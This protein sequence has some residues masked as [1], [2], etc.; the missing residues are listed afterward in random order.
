MLSN[1]FLALTLS[2]TQDL[3]FSYYCYTDY[4]ESILCWWYEHV[5]SIVNLGLEKTNRKIVLGENL[6]MFH[7]WLHLLK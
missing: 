5:F 3:F 1:S 6:N 2:Q 7:S 4:T